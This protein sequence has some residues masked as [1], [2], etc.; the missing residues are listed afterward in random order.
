MQNATNAL[1]VL[2]LEKTKLEN[3]FKE[4]EVSRESDQVYMVK[5]LNDSCQKVEYL[6][7]QLAS[8]K[9]DTETEE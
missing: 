7:K 9:V 1:T 5:L 6:Q 3:K 2:K 4:T 8:S